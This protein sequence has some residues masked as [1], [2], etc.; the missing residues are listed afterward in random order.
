MHTFIDYLISTIKYIRW[1]DTRALIGYN[2][3]VQKQ[4]WEAMKPYIK[5]SGKETFEVWNYKPDNNMLSGLGK[6]SAYIRDI[7]YEFIERVID[8]VD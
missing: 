1:R 6:H 4:M 3:A 2:E 8:L 5:P 7:E